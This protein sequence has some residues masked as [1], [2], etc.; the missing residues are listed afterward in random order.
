MGILR[1]FPWFSLWTQCSTVNP[2]SSYCGR[3]VLWT[4][5]SGLQ[6]RYDQNCFS[7]YFFINH[8]IGG[9]STHI[10]HCDHPKQPEKTIVFRAVALNKFEKKHF[11]CERETNVTLDYQELQFDS[12]AG[13]VELK[14]KIIDHD[15]FHVNKLIFEFSTFSDQ[16]LSFH[17]HIVCLVRDERPIWDLL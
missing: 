13:F 7:N 8:I 17:L 11:F 9:E 12:A 14:S 3:V 15:I 16:A 5:K 4:P 2:A 10:F 6:V 1:M